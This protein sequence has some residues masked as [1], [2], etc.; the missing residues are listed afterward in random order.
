MLFAAARRG[1]GR[2]AQHRQG[3]RRPRRKTIPPHRASAK[4]DLRLVPGQTA[5]EALAQRKAQLAK[6]AY[7]DIAVAMTGSSDPTR[8][9]AGAAIIQAQV[10]VLRRA[11]IEPVLG[12][13]WPA[14]IPAMY[15]PMRPWRSP[16]DT[17]VW[18]TAPTPTPPTGALSSSRPPRK[19]RATTEPPCRTSTISSNWRSEPSDVWCG[20]PPPGH[21]QAPVRRTAQ[22]GRPERRGPG[23]APAPPMRATGEIRLLDAGTWPS[24]ARPFPEGVA[25][26]A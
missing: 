8:T 25:P 18:A 4:L 12:R 11:G 3:R 16:Q 14:P 15:S 19:C 13:G 26:A 1:A 9:P 7:G 24:E 10:A 2:P 21:R 17:A 23:P 22:R 6:R 5:A 20:P